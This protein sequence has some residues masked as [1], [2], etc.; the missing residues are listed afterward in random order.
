MNFA[1]RILGELD[2]R[3]DSK[4][5]LALYGRAA[6]VLGFPD[7]ENE[8]AQSY[9]VD[10]V[11]W[12]GQ[13]AE[14]EQKSNFWE[15]LEAV[16]LSLASEGLY[17]SHLFGE[18][19]VIL[20]PSWRILRRSILGPWTNLELSRLADEDLLL[21]KLMR[22]DPQDREDALFLVRV[23]KWDRAFVQALADEARVPEISELQEEFVNAKRRLLMEMGKDQ[24][25]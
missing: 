13:D 22:D 21:S 12:L 5:E 4:V 18:E 6:F 2:K 25:S 3:L 23:N 14:L 1:Q 8:F 15:A 20:R 19:Q 7:L 11:L 10:A 17:M 24:S 9:D 16:N